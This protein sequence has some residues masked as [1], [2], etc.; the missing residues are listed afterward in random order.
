MMCL[1]L[2]SCEIPLS[3][4]IVAD[5]TDSHS[6]KIAFAKRDS[7]AKWN[8]QRCMF[9]G[10]SLNF[11][12]IHLFATLCSLLSFTEHRA[13]DNSL[14]VFLL[15]LVLRFYFQLR[16]VPANERSDGEEIKKLFLWKRVNH[17]RANGEFDEKVFSLFRRPSVEYFNVRKE[18][19]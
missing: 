15:S 1:F 10:L 14:F 9:F 16:I 5:H 6:I 13:N 11:K 7:V 17:L 3:S 12:E 2:V 4:S 8:A 19:V 18:R